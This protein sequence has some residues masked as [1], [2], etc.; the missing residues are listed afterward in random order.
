MKLLIDTNIILDFLLSRA[1]K[2]YAK[3]IFELT[4]DNDT[5]EY[6]S[7]T[8]I[9]DIFYIIN[10]QIKDSHKTQSLIRKLL[11]FISVSNVTD[12]DIEMALN[13]DWND[14]EDAV[15][16]AVAKSNNVDAIITNNKK[17]FEKNDISI[18]TAKEFLDSLENNK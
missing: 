15:Q 7:S 8:S 5:Y 18:M 10:K 17:D 13:M 2:D 1:N 9:T 4:L 14:F 11:T 6:L 12:K 16:Y 3:K